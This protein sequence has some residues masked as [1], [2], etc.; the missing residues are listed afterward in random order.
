MSPNDVENR[1]NSF[2]DGSHQLPVHMKIMMDS[3]EHK[4]KVLEQLD[5]CPAT[6]PTF[7]IPIF[8][9]LSNTCNNYQ[10]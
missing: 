2:S 5:L 6:A 7:S 9:L 8:A 4:G 10:G 3:L 1:G